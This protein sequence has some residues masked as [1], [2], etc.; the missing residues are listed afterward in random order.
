M[1]KPRLKALRKAAGLTQMLLAAKAG[2]S[3][4]HYRRWETGERPIPEEHLAK[5]ATLLKTTPAE[6]TGPPLKLV[7]PKPLDDDDDDASYSERDGTYFGEVTV[8]FIG[9]GKPLMLSISNREMKLLFKA[10]QG[11]DYFC[12]VESLANQTVVL[13]AAAIADLYL[14]HDN[15][16][17]YGPEHD[18]KAP[19]RGY[20]NH[21]PIIDFEPADWDVVERLGW[22]SFVPEEAERVKR[23]ETYLDELKPVGRELLERV[24]STMTYQLSSGRQRNVVLPHEGRDLYD[25]LSPLVEFPESDPAEDYG[26]NSMVYFDF[27]DLHAHHAFINPRAFDYISVPTHK[28]KKGA[29]EALKELEEA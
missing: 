8:H 2:V 18:P 27:W 21:V 16:D 15:G 22:D 7:E 26:V 11:G 20:A 13:R 28:Y 14:A 5:L 17:T 24:A 6:I 1:T 19:D 4:P 3:Q 12:I 9:G 10:I 23:V 29:D 25:N